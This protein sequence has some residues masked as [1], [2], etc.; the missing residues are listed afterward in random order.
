MEREILQKD[1]L[2]SINIDLK[3]ILLKRTLKNRLK[4]II[5]LLYYFVFALFV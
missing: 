2:F 5:L 1:I 4:K 3:K